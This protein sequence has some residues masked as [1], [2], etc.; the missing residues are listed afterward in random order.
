MP[1]SMRVCPSVCMCV[2]WR[3]RLRLHKR[4]T[5]RIPICFSFIVHSPKSVS[6]SLG[7]RG[8]VVALLCAGRRRH[9]VQRNLKSS[10]CVCVCVCVSVCLSAC[11][12]LSPCVC[13]RVCRSFLL[14]V[15]AAAGVVAIC[16]L[17]CASR[18]SRGLAG[19]A[20]AAIAGRRRSG[21]GSR[22]E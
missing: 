5:N 16:L 4:A 2:R 3:L 6:L 10:V 20:N 12:H 14:V 15:G 18:S 13:V 17:A 11:V 22:R 21:V 19:F 9:R 1:E 7:L 8:L